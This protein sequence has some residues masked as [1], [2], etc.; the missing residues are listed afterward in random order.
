MTMFGEAGA[1]PR[2]P[3]SLGTFL[4]TFGFVMLC[5]IVGP[6]FLVAYFLIDE[7]GIEWMLWTGLGVTLLDVT[8]GVAVA[9]AA[10]G[11]QGRSSRLKATG[12]VAI[13][14]IISIEQTSVQINDQPLMKLGLHIHGDDMVAFDVE[15][16]VVVP[17]FQQGLLHARRLSVLVDPVSNDFEIDWQ[18]TAL[19]AGSVPARFTSVADGKTYDITGQPEPLAEIIAILHRYGVPAGGTIDLRSNPA[20]REEVLDVV[21]GFTATTASATTTSATTTA[22]AGA[23]ADSAVA[24]PDVASRPVAERLADLDD[25]RRR[26]AISESEH[27]AARQRI[28]GSI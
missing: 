25:L 2:V 18:A 7:P 9:W 11:R 21:R 8:I 24:G 28:L 4:G 15:K 14:D 13:A 12:R 10:A 17:V 16:R 3:R 5:G 23:G 20:A 26:G 1:G 6:I 22:P 19:L 27:T